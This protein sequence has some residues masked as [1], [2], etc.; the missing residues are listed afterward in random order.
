[1]TIEVVQSKSKNKNEIEITWSDFGKKSNDLEFL[2]QNGT[3]IGETS[4]DVARYLS[5]AKNSKLY[6]MP[7]IY[8]DDYN[9]KIKI[10]IHFLI[11]RK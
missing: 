9:S 7:L 6:G 10:I 11:F 2:D 4:N 8:F 5:R 1:M 3:I